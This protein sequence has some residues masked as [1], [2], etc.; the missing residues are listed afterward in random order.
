MSKITTKIG[1]NPQSGQF[2][3]G[4]KASSKISEIEGL[5]FSKSMSGTFMELT[6]DDKPH[7]GRRDVL[8]EKFGAKR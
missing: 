5:R 6:K 7:A 3:I 4:W 8:K 2:V 1:R